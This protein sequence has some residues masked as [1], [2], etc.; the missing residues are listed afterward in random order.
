MK[1]QCGGGEV[2]NIISVFFGRAN[3]VTCPTGD[4]SNQSCNDPGAKHIIST[5][6]VCRIYIIST[7]DADGNY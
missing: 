6:Y 7:E 2:L 5:M 1:L 4:L 3:G